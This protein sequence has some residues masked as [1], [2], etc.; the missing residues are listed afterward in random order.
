MQAEEKGVREMS[1]KPRSC[2]REP[3]Q[4]FDRRVENV[5]GPLL[6]QNGMSIMLA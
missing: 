3:K 1:G 6:R 5:K 4:D 2:S